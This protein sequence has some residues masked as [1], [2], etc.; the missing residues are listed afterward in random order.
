MFDVS[1]GLRKEEERQRLLRIQAGQASG[2]DWAACLVLQAL[3]DKYGFGR[4]RFVQMN[5]KF[6]EKVGQFQG[7]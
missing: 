5:E 2:I 4:R 3:H 7:C 6:E 1:S